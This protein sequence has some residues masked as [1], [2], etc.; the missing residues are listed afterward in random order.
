MNYSELMIVA[1]QF[2]VLKITTLL[3]GGFIIFSPFKWPSGPNPHFHSLIYHQIR[4][5]PR[6]PHGIEK[7]I[8]NHMPRKHPNEIYPQNIR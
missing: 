4:L 6:N 5:N 3:K 7:L 8:S 2:A 1:D